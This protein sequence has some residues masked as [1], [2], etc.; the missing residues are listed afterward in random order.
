MKNILVV[1]P[2]PDDA[3]FGCGGFI[4]KEVEK[5]SKVTIALCTGPGDLKMVHSGQTVSFNQRREEQ[6]KAVEVLGCTLKFLSL[7]EASRFDQVPI[8]KFVSKFDEL[9]PSYGTVLIPL[10]SFAKDHTIVYEAALAAMRPGKVDGVEFVAYEEPAQGSDRLYL[11][12]T[13]YCLEQRHLIRKLN[14]IEAHQSQVKGREHT[15][16][17]IRGAELMCQ[18]R[19]EE[20]GE[21]FAEVFYLIRSKVK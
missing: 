10:P 19:G 1:S 11:G 5:G 17:S 8:A 9:F 13:Y 3:E 4:A 14:A 15:F 20:I 16:A 21:R 18:M 6:E 7:A 2:H 12:R